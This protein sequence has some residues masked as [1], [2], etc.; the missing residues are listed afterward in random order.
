[1]LFVLQM[2]PS[3]PEKSLGGEDWVV[4]PKGLSCFR[5]K[6]NRP[7]SGKQNHSLQNL[8]FVKASVAGGLFLFLR[9]LLRSQRKLKKISKN[10]F[11]K[12][13]LAS[14]ILVKKKKKKGSKPNSYK[15]KPVFA[16]HKPWN[17]SAQ[18]WDVRMLWFNYS[19]IQ[20]LKVSFPTLPLF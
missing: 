2:Q 18:H 3:V 13:D 7:G 9:T 17:I 15:Q 19:N 12:Y 6:T 4:Y 5:A 11:T 8:S 1:M 10:S 16:C 20:W 14:G